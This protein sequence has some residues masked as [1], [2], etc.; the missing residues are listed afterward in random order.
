M[1]LLLD[2]ILHQANE[3]YKNCT[4][5]HSEIRSNQVKAITKVLV[6][7]IQTLEKRITSL[8]MQIR[9]NY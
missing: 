9:N 8:E 7:Y 4:A 2:E 3:E 6:E 1:N 5:S